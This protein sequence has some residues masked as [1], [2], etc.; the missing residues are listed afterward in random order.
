MKV[1][2]LVRDNVGSI[3]IIVGINPNG[4]C[5]VQIR[6]HVFLINP[7]WLEVIS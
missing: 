1:G 6:E 7:Q 5:K 3:G 4:D 2:D